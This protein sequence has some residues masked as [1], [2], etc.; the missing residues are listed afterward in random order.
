MEGSH[1]FWF[2]REKREVNREAIA[3]MRNSTRGYDQS[4]PTN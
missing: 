2:D 3:L 4:K 1:G